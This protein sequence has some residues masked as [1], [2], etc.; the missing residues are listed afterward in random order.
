MPPHL[1]DGHYGGAKD[2]GNAVGYIYP[3]DDPSGVVN[4]QYLPESL[5]KARYYLP[6]DHGNEKR[7][8]GVVEKLHAIVRGKVLK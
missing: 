5:L 6:T 1:R 3:H 7:L 8:A 2:L 4:Q